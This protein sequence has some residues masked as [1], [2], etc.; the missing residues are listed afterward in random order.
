[1]GDINCL[2]PTI[3][4]SIHELSNLFQTLQGDTDLN[5]L[6][7]LSS[8]AEKE[9]TLVEKKLQDAHIDHLDPKVACNLVIFLAV[10]FPTGTLMQG[11]DYILE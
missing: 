1:M 6:R 2:R 10:H 5:S 3:G 4:L 9:L 8:Q 7:I 11:E